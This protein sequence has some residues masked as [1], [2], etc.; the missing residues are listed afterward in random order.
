MLLDF[1]KEDSKTPVETGVHFI[2]GRAK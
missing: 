2:L 1:L